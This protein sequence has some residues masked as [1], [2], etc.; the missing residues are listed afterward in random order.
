[1]LADGGVLLAGFDNPLRYL[2]DEELAE[3][4]ASKPC[5]SSLGGDRLGREMATED[6][7]PKNVDI[8]GCGP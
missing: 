5:G 8:A 2:F 1:V 3:R 4:P 6:G 7:V